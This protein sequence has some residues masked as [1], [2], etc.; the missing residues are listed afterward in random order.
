MGKKK[1]IGLPGGPNEFL[2]DIT[3]Y[4]SVEGFKS[5]SPD[6]NNPVNIIESGSI[7]MQDVDF[8][9]LGIDNL[10][11]SQMMFPEND[12]QFPGDMVMEV[13]E[14]QLGGIVKLLKAGIK[15][16]PKYM[17]DITK[18]AYKYNP[19]A[20]NNIDSKLP[21]IL[22]FNR[23]NDSWLR[24]VGRPAIDDVK[25][26]G[27][28]REL[29]EVIDPKL[30][31][32]KIKALQNQ[33]SGINF[34]IGKRYPGPFFKK[35][36]TFFDM[37]KIKSTNKKYD[38]KRS[39][40]GKSGSAEY[41]IESGP[42]IGDD[43]FQPAYMQSMFR[44]VGEKGIGDIAIMK[45]FGREA[46]N[47]NF[48]KKDWWD[49]Y[50]RTPLDE[51]QAGGGLVG[52]MYKL[53][54]DDDYK[55]T[56]AL[57]DNTLAPLSDALDVVSIPGALIGELGES[58][59][60]RGDGEFN[61]TDAM[62][63]FKGDY[64]FENMN[65]E[66]LKNLA[67]LK[68]KD[69]NPL[70]DN[71][72]GAF[73]LNVAT[74]PSTYVGAGVLKSALKKGVTKS[75]PLIKASADDMVEVFTSDGSRKLMKKADAIRLN[76][77]EDANVNN[78]TFTNYED[79]NWF[80]D[81]I[82]P[83]Y[84]NNAKSALKGGLLNPAD[85]KRVM[86]AYLDPADAKLFDVGLK[87]TARARNMSGGVGK[88]A[89]Q[90]E[91][92]LPP[93]LVKIMRE[94][95]SGPGF[96]TMIGNS[97][98]IMNNLDAFYKK[99]GGGVNKAQFGLS[100]KIDQFRKNLAANYPTGMGYIPFEE[101]VN[102][103]K[104][105]F[106]SG[107]LQAIKKS[108]TDI[109]KAGTNQVDYDRAYDPEAVTKSNLEQNAFNIYLQQEQVGDNDSN[110]F[111]ISKYRPSK[112]DTPEDV[113]YSIP[114]EQRK[115]VYGDQMF[116]NILPGDPDYNYDALQEKYS[117]QEEQDMVVGTYTKGIGKNDDG[118]IYL[119]AY[120]KWDLNP[121][122]QLRNNF[123]SNNAFF[124]YIADNVDDLSMG[125]GKPFNIYDRVNYIPMSEGNS[126]VKKY[127]K[128]SKVPEWEE[129][130]YNRVVSESRKEQDGGSITPELLMKQAY[131]ESNWDPNIVNSKGYTGLGQI[132]LQLAEDYKKANKIKG[133]IN[134][135]D[136]KVNADIQKWSMNELMNSSFINK[137][138]STDEV[139]LAKALAAYNWGRGNMSKMLVKQKDAGVDIYKSLDWLS[140][141][142]K[143]TLEYYKMITTDDFNP[144][145]R[146]LMQQD[147]LKALENDSIIQN[148]YKKSGGEYS[149]FKDYVNG[150]YN[151]TKH[152]NHA[153][154]I[155]DKLNR[156][157][158]REAKEA[159]MSPA[160][161]IM[162]N[163]SR[164]S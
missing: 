122:S 17:D 91:Y 109:Y 132:G 152:E 98:S 95:T 121:L 146:P 16:A 15:Q 130:G 27:V 125:L 105:K 90:G 123:N 61:F 103:N 2:Q 50:K 151:N 136:P 34:Y 32:E 51:L 21:E 26:T 156:I 46:S 83:F 40:R 47:F 37:K 62:P 101:T 9:V 13:P 87:G 14:K 23:E 149:V 92:V 100:A 41:L 42:S 38:G 63:G 58:I 85:P 44:D 150:K 6:K 94:G 67:G 154:K 99:L 137:G 45:P 163:I 104:R 97:E 88:P 110:K 25:E 20:Y 161:F 5:Y 153:E 12:Y 4:I 53:A 160:N 78:K 33:Q 155:Y 7:T 108:L 120:D 22:Q 49:G 93:A 71:A 162:T 54:T 29:N 124:N 134:L 57:Y 81:D 112:G 135:L 159:G 142:P 128:E 10:G 145:T 69:G 76:R 89:L 106:G 3:Q 19:W 1:S 59:T 133:D 129:K 28:V 113:Y 35:G 164:Y 116:P 66:Q 117:G 80:S 141:L 74:D 144:E 118:S 72:V 140:E 31:D 102:A 36:E 30:F 111:T 52:S 131:V 147:Y 18:N 139:K 79:G 11:N 84:I 148:Y 143:E 60:G 114:P 127:I 86:S 107:Y 75:A 55:W 157:H 96:N 158:Y 70:V 39:T 65:G 73:L 77:I 43:F 68:D 56:D 8:P 126:S 24:Q 115:R 119:S 48:Y 138:N 82:Q 64:S